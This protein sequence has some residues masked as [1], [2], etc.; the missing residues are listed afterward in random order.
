MPC[1]V[2]FGF[3]PVITACSHHD[4]LICNLHL[5]TQ[6]L[7]SSAHSTTASTE[8]TQGPIDAT[9]P[10]CVSG[11]SRTPNTTTRRK[12][13]RLDDADTTAITTITIAHPERATQAPCGTRTVPAPN[14]DSRPEGPWSTKGSILRG[15]K[16]S[17]KRC[18]CGRTNNNM[19]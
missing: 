4:L 10:R 5:L 8:Y 19:I 13:F 18:F 6:G 12:S 15:T 17:G 14:I 9:Y 1:H 7:P 11:A 2:R 3:E 16:L